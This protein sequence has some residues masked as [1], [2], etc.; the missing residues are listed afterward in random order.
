VGGGE[1][2]AVRLCAEIKKQAPEHSVFLV[3]LYDATP[4]MV[5][6]EAR[7][8]SAEIICLGKKKGFSP[9]T[10]I[11]MMVALN[12]I[13]PDVIHTHLA[14]LRYTLLAGLMHRQALKLHTVHNMASRETSPF[15]TRVHGFAFKRLGWL[16]VALSEIVRGSI[17]DV[18][19]L[20]ATVV[21][22]GIGIQLSSLTSTKEE[23]KLALGLPFKH[24]IVTNIGRL[25]EQKNQAILIDAFR[26]LCKTNDEC[27]LLLIGDDTTGGAYRRMLEVKVS[28]LPE[29]VRR[30]IRFLGIRSDIPQLLLASDVFVLSSDWEGVPLTLLEAMGYGIP[31]VCTS[32]GG[33]PDVI[34]HAV[35]GM[36]VSK[37]NANAL[38]E[39]LERVLMNKGFASSLSLSGQEKFRRRYSIDITT[40]KYLELYQHRSKK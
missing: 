26:I 32:V 23:I 15:L 10:P 35:D 5:Y 4:T 7:A 17:R 39:A 31:S 12:R 3:S 1:L 37:G 2:L 14:G 38:S 20:D 9:Y 34:E 13:K 19:G 11:K 25:C 29:N 16:P 22:N 18:Y 28:G 6:E 30:N 36:L 40:K 27:S 8:S 33:I 24:S 21:D